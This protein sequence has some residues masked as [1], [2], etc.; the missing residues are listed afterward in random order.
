[1]VNCDLSV[2]YRIIHN[3]IGISSSSLFNF[4]TGQKFAL[5]RPDIPLHLLP[6][7]F[8]LRQL[9]HVKVFVKLV[10]DV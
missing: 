2:R 9:G 10:T 5:Y 8:D 7:L 3:T 4:F 1:M 6:P